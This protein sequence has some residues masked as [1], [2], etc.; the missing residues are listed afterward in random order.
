MKWTKLSPQRICLPLIVGLALGSVLAP[1]LHA[2]AGIPGGPIRGGLIPEKYR[3]HAMAKTDT[4]VGE[5]RAA[6]QVDAPGEVAARYTENALLVLPDGQPLVG[7]AEIERRLG[8]LLSRARDV[9]L[10]QLD[11]D[12]GTGIA[13]RTGSFEMD[14]GDGPAL[15]GQ[16]LTVLMRKREGWR[17]RSQF[18]FPEPEGPSLP[19]DPSVGGPLSPHRTAGALARRNEWEDFHSGVFAEVNRATAD[20]TR[21]WR[22]G[23]VATAADAYGEHATLQLWR[24]ERCEGKPAIDACLRD[25]LPRVGEARAAVLDFD[26]AGSLA[27]VYGR[28]YMEVEGGDGARE[29]VVGPYVLIFRVDSSARIR[30]HVLERILGEG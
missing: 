7:R 14:F 6:W 10:G 26:A 23:D 24:S 4:L 11:F 21:A 28:Y 20:L 30:A 2:Q 9:Q 3:A 8:N 29:T 22:E 27:Y 5:W 13:F 19:A 16:H 1:A 25:L 17:I 15:R 12:A 18:F